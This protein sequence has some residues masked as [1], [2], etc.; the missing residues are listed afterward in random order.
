MRG[1]VVRNLRTYGR[2][3][4]S[5]GL[6]VA[7]SC[8]FLLV[9]FGFSAGVSNIMTRSSQ[10]G[11]VGAQAVV[12]NETGQVDDKLW[13][14][15][16]DKLQRDPQIQSVYE[17][18]FGTLVLKTKDDD[19]QSGFRNLPPAP[20]KGPDLESGK[21]PV[22]ERELLLPASLAK[23]Y[24]VKLGDSV[25]IKFMNPQFFAT[26]TE[27][28]K[29]DTS[30]TDESP[31]IKEF[32]N[33]KV[34]GLMADTAE[35]LSTIYLPG[36][37]CEPIFKA[38]KTHGTT[39][40][41]LFK[42]QKIS[43]T[44]ALKYV[45][46]LADSLKI[47]DEL[48]IYSASGYLTKQLNTSTNSDSTALAIMLI[49]PGIALATAFMVVSSTFKV[50][51]FQRKR[52]LALLRCLGGTSQQL[53]NLALGEALLVGVVASIFGIGLGY[54][55]AATVNYLVGLSVSFWETFTII[56]PFS[57]LIVFVVGTLLT[58]FAGIKPALRVQRYTPLQALV[59]V[60]T[61]QEQRKSKV[62]SRSIWSVVLALSVFVILYGWFANTGEDAQGTRFLYMFFGGFFSFIA[63][64]PLLAS[65][66]P[67]LTWALGKFFSR[68]M[69]SARLAGENTK[70]NHSRTAAT[71]TGLLLG[72]VLVSTLLVGTHSLK[73]SLQK[74]LDE[75]KPFD[76]AVSYSQ[77]QKPER[78]RDMESLKG[79][80]GVMT[81]EILDTKIVLPGNVPNNQQT[82]GTSGGNLSADEK[83]RTIGNFGVAKYQEM[84]KFLR[85]KLNPPPTGV[86]YLPAYDTY[87]LKSDASVVI[88]VKD[89]EYKL[90]VKVS[91]VPVPMVSSAQYQQMVNDTHYEDSQ[92]LSAYLL[93][94]KDSLQVEQALK[95]TMN[96]MKYDQPQVVA[97]CAERLMY[98]TVLDVLAWLIIG[99]L[100]VSVLV[101]LIGVSNTLALGIIER[102][103]E[104]AMLRAIGL[105][106]SGLRRMLGMEALLLSLTALLI[107]IPLGILYGWLGLESLPIME[108]V[109]MSL[110]VP[111]LQLLGLGLVVLGATLLASLLPARRAAKE[112]P[113]LGIQSL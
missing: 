14:D 107:G 3:Y 64:L 34:V 105:T 9:C 61:V 113:V 79:I 77:P 76:Y 11:V 20:L 36:T 100:A 57:L 86:L 5:V 72:M 21:Q 27:D 88:K 46:T 38:L 108:G 7:V 31:F 69:P 106:R 44:D 59:P 102:R 42:D 110:V 111:W 10:I 74:V 80:E 97:P 55:A 47:K 82:E 52:E 4:I 45:G 66:V 56:S 73:Y 87:G 89:H 104:N 109:R 58:L 54:L 19:T 94:A 28:N 68:F 65:F 75:H 84:G 13:Q 90:K 99:L 25:E 91:R 78:I 62:V 29:L 49:F 43:T 17:K 103:R 6:A 67:N 98:Q 81:L 96:L 53:F 2:R 12:E 51:F 92:M 112:T 70:L 26:A 50:V 48:R 39:L 60:E 85:T 32:Q 15:F 1:L 41:V 37:A 16:V 83:E 24:G 40:S 8:A 35:N 93:K 23:S 95:I 33:F 101:A 30:K 18:R 71:V 22:G 63:V